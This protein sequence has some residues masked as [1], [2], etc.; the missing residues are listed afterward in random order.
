GTLSEAGLRRTSIARKLAALRTFCKYLCRE[1]VL[2]QNPVTRVS[3]PKLSKTLPHFMYQD[4]VALLL[5]M[6]DVSTFQG[7]RDRAIL[8]ILYASGLRVSE[9]ANLDVLDL[10]L[11]LNLVKVFG[12]GSRERIVPLGSYA[13]SALQAYLAARMNF[14]PKP[15]EKALFLNRFGTRLTARS[16]RRVVETCVNAAAL[17]GKISPHT[18]RHSFATHL[19]DRGADLRSV[20]ELLGHIKLSSTQIYTHVTKERLKEV[21]QKFHPREQSLGKE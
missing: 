3:S 8:E 11:D 14:N 9:L 20:Q 5:E 15:G 17:K 21:Y 16:V 4:E 1:L 19:L 6:P 10:E 18:L 13:K 12:K 7:L 2:D